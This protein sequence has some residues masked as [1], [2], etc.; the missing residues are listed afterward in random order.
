VDYHLPTIS[1]GSASGDRGPADGL[2]RILFALRDFACSCGCDNWGDGGYGGTV[3]SIGNGLTRSLSTAPGFAWYN[4]VGSFAAL[5]RCAAAGWLSSAG[6]GLSGWIAHRL[7]VT[8]Y[9]C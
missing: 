1:G 9:G 3:L 4:L 6:A 8:G 2:R 5:G 7:V